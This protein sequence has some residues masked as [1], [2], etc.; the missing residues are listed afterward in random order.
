MR[1]EIIFAGFGG[2]GIILS[3]TIICLAA[4]KEGKKVSKARLGRGTSAAYQALR[5]EIEHLSNDRT[6]YP[7]LERMATMVHSG[8]IL[9]TVETALGI[10]LQGVAEL[11]VKPS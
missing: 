8:Q 5:Q 7:D 10:P 3:G 2:Q 11:M 1:E 4:M 6:L 9:H